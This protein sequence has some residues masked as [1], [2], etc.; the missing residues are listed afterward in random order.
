MKKSELIQIIREEVRN[1]LRSRLNEAFKS[2]ILRDIIKTLQGSTRFGVAKDFANSFVKQ[3]KIPLDQVTDNDIQ[4]MSPDAAYKMIR[5]SGDPRL[6]VVFMNK[7]GGTNPYAKEKWNTKIPPNSIIAIANGQ[8]MFLD[9]AYTRYSREPGLKASKDSSGIG[10]EK[11]GGRFGTGI[12]NVKRASEVSDVAYVIDSS[13]LHASGKDTSALQSLRTTQKTGAVAF[14]TPEQFRKDNFARYKEILQNQAAATPVDKMVMEFINL[15]TAAITKA[16]STATV[17]RYDQ[18]TVGTLK[19]KD[20]TA[21]DLS[22]TMRNV[23]DNFERYT[24]YMKQAA[25]Y[26]GQESYYIPQAKAYALQ[27]K[28]E[29]NLIKTLK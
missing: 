12:V 25:K 24:S 21:S 19:G 14:M 13:K 8:N 1:V 7:A 16:V 17:N 23:L 4:E 26:A 9:V 18:I 6:Y 11:S 29:L 20:V 2:S 15:A 22:Y 28:E 3:S 27:I 5:K 10:I